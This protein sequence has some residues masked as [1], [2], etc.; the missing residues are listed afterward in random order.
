MTRFNASNYREIKNTG[1]KSQKIE[2]LLER[3]TLNV[4]YIMWKSSCLPLTL[5][6]PT[7]FG[8]SINTLN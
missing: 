2:P 4:V 8:H 6:P 3:E 1:S 7:L 5:S